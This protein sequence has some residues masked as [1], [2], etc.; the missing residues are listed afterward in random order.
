MNPN[1]QAGPEGL[2]FSPHL[3]YRRAQ[4][5]FPGHWSGGC[6]RLPE[7]CQE[8][9]DS[10][11]QM[12]TEGSGGQGEASPAVVYSF[13]QPASVRHGSNT[14]VL[15]VCSRASSISMSWELLEMQIPGP[16]SSA[17]GLK[18]LCV[19]PGNLCFHLRMLKFENHYSRSICQQLI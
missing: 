13:L 11:L 2:T 5:L 6:L 18:P 4:A 14:A 8:A 12:H 17:T 10:G 15:K 9:L 16:H 3:G 1:I 19:G 7:A